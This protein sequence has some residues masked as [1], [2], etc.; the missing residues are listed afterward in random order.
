MDLIATRDHKTERK[1]KEMGIKNRPIWGLT[2]DKLLSK[3]DFT[4]IMQRILKT[5]ENYYQY[6]VDIEF[7]V[8][9]T[10]DDKPK[11]NLVQCRPLQ[12]K[13]LRPN[14]R[15]PDNIKIEKILFESCGYTMGGNISQ[16]I[17]R[18]IYVEPQAYIGLTL[19]QKYDIA[20]LVGNLNRQI[21]NR[22]AMPTIL[23]GPGRWGTTTPSLGVPV[24]FSEINNVIGLVEVAYEGANL[25][26][27]LSFGTHFFQDLVEGDIFYIALFPKKEEVTL[28]KDLFAKMPNL[29]ADVMPESEKYAHVVKVYSTEKEKLQ[30]MCDILSQKVICI[31][32]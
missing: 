12:T 8:N 23:F 24:S 2:F 18:V 27:D 30:I 7:T 11:I 20:R 5:L 10:E 26:P 15:I 9:F 31:F 21:T 29:L 22:D 1:I 6:P 14:V 13:G 32:A 3:T 16:S 4:Q 28:N 19:T 25:M 17:K